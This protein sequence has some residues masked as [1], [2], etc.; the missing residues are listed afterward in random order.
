MSLMRPVS[1]TK[2]KLR[3]SIRNFLLEFGCG[4]YE[5][6]AAGFSILLAEC[7]GGV[8]G[9]WCGPACDCA[10]LSGWMKAWAGVSGAL[11]CAATRA[12]ATTKDYRRGAPTASGE[13]PGAE[14]GNTNCD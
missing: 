7:Y 6:A 14:K 1:E 8:N 5:R 3:F 13:T 12:K 10:R 2:R 4:A 9:D 11:K